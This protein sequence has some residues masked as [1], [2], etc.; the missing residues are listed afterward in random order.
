[1]KLF[2]ERHAEGCRFLSLL[3]SAGENFNRSY[4][5]FMILEARHVPGKHIGNWT[6]P[7]KISFNLIEEH[8]FYF[9]SIIAGTAR[10]GNV[11]DV[12]LSKSVLRW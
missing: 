11:R 6:A 5:Y 10:R 1:M 9:L 7:S 12:F 2:L 4:Q 3:S 8:E